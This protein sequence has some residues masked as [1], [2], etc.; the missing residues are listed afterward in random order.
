VIFLP[1]SILTS[2][3]N[4]TGMICKTTQLIL[5]YFVVLIFELIIIDA[6][7]NYEKVYLTNMSNG[8]YEKL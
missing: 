2:T 1:I 8:R 3:Y 5:Q 7:F 4:H 6:N